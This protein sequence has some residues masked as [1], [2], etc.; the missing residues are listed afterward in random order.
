MPLE[1][2]SVCEAMNYISTVPDINVGTKVM[3]MVI[4]KLAN[5]IP[6]N[7]KFLQSSSRFYFNSDSLFIYLF[8]LTM[9]SIVDL[10]QSLLG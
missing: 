8:L 4:G 10:I 5:A 7:S 9:I 6:Q 1:F 3:G 2:G